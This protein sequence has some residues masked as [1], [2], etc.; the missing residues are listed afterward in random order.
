MAKRKKSSVFNDDNDVDEGENGFMNYIREKADR[1][2]KRAKDSSVNFNIAENEISDNKLASNDELEPSRSKYMHQLLESK[3]RR[4]LD[5]LHAQSVK[6]KLERKLEGFEDAEE[7]VTGGYRQKKEKYEQADEL[8]QDE[9]DKEAI[10]NQNSIFGAEGI[11]LK[12]MATEMSPNSHQHPVEF[13]ER[14]SKPVEIHHSNDVYINKSVRSRLIWEKQDDLNPLQ[15]QECVRKFL[16]PK[17]TKQDIDIL[18]KQYL[19]RHHSVNN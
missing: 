3:K 14:Y 19:E 2:K 6:I 5:K 7:I 13:N 16:Q 8:A 4:E 1:S 17:K 15:K 10:D 11:A 18:I 9:R 12:T